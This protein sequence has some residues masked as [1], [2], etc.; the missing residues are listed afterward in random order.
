VETSSTVIAEGFE[1]ATK[2]GKRA[3]MVSWLSGSGIEIGALHNPLVVPEGASVRYVDRLREDQLREHY[4]ELGEAQ[5]APVSIIG[6]AEH[7]DSLQDCSVDFVI[8]NHLVE[9]LENTLQGMRE[10]HRVLRPGGILYLALPDPRATFDRERPLT[11]VDHVVDEF[12]RG[13]AA[14]R[15]R[16]YEEWVDLVEP[17][18]DGWEHLLS[19]E[20]LTRQGRLRMLMDMDYSIHFHVWRPETFVQLLGAAR[21]V[22]NIRYDLVAFAPCVLGEDDEFI[23]VLRKAKQRP[24]PHREAVRLARRAGEEL[25]SGGPAAL[26]SGIRR[27]LS[28]RVDAR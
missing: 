17:L 22:C 12:R 19:G 3:R 18:L 4:P 10:M 6:D 27:R 2:A 23:F 25:R 16:H 1:A 7:L 5:F 9:H 8:A 15:R 24:A 13:P 20:Q 21:R 28:R 26:A 11:S 14:N